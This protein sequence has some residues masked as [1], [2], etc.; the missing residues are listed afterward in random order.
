M[1]GSGA[2]A[3][4]LVTDRS[5]V[6]VRASWPSMAPSAVFSCPTP[7]VRLV[8]EAL[9]SLRAEASLVSPSR[10]CRAALR[11]EVSEASALADALLRLL[12]MVES[13]L[14]I[15]ATSSSAP[16]PFEPAS[17]RSSCATASADPGDGCSISRPRSATSAARVPAATCCSPCVRSR[18]P[19]SV[20]VA[21]FTWPSAAESE[22]ASSRPETSCSAPVL[23]V[24]TLSKICG[25]EP[26]EVFRPFP[27]E[28]TALDS[29]PKSARDSSAALRATRVFSAFSRSWAGAGGVVPAAMRKVAPPATSAISTASSAV[30]VRAH[31]ERA[32]ARSGRVSFM[33]M[34]QP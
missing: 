17:A 19:V 28:T 23:A 22:D 34:P 1:P 18:A 20:A 6:C 30:P 14:R 29:R 7:V 3:G 9:T 31:A 13:V 21:R 10:S 4:A 12:V 15:P 8:T 16:T 11:A 24:S 25:T 26:A 33:V 2:G 27:A 5:R 32:A